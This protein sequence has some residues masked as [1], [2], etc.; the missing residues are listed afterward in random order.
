MVGKVLISSDIK[1]FLQNYDLLAFLKIFRN[2]YNF[3]TGSHS[4]G[5][6]HGTE[7]VFLISNDR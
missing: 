6:L 3:G 1:K 4:R 7:L 5:L 2:I